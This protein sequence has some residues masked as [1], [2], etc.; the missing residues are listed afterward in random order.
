MLT[1]LPAI[2]FVLFVGARKRVTEL[3]RCAVELGPSLVP[4]LF[5]AHPRQVFHGTA[6][7]REE[8]LDLT[9]ELVG[10]PWIASFAFEDG[11]DAGA[12]LRNTLQQA[13]TIVRALEPP[14]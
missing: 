5:R 4:P 7:F 2:A 6:D 9:E 12:F 14:E 1:A 11:S 8:S 3:T 10:T 13:A